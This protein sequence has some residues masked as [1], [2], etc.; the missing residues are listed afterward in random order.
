MGGRC[1]VMCATVRGVRAE[2]VEVEVAVSSGLPAFHVVGMGDTAVQESRARVKAAISAAGF[3]MPAERVVVNLAPSS[4]R[5]TGTGFDLAIAIG[6]LLITK[7]IPAEVVQGRMFVGELS[8]EGFVR[9]VDGL[10]AYA[11]AARDLGIELVCSARG[12]EVIDVAGVSQVGV[13][14]LRDLLTG[15]FVP[16]DPVR[17]EVAAPSIDYADIGGNDAAK[18]ALQV[19]A[20]GSHGVLMMGPPGSGKTM[21]AQRVPTILPPLDEDEALE[22]A[23]I[24]SVAGQSIAGILAGVRPFRSPHHSAT[25]AGLIGGGSPIRPGEVSLA[26]NGVLMLDELAEFKPATLQMMR[27]PMEDGEVTITRA[28]GTL[29]FPAHFMLIAAT[30]PCPCGY[31]GDPEHRCTCSETQV[32]AYRNRIGGPL[33]D[34]IDMHIDVARVPAGNVLSAGGGVSSA[35]LLEGVLA[36]R[37]YR[38]WRQARMEDEDVGSKGPARIVAACKLDDSD[39]AF[40]R[41]ACKANKMSG[42]ALLRTLSVARTI[43]DLDQRERVEKADLCEALNYRTR[44]GGA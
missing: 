18:R 2:P 19:A 31:F 6:I 28:D 43:A 37:E 27:Q 16:L 38:C 10:I 13:N 14:T 3:T 41:Q 44:E 36:A 29:T 22:T 7:Q 25:S 12:S 23:L 34:R 5:K 35:V 9:P 8:L 39:M 15:S 24:Y 40:Y 33:M 32:N 21:L 11:F 42:R 1:S 17:F 20:A 4:L 26:H 30:N